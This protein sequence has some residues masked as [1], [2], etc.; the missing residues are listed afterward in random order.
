MMGVRFTA[1]GS[2][3]KNLWVS[4]QRWGRAMLGEGRVNARATEGVGELQ[5]LLDRIH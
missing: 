3:Q 4:G 5:S 2:D 1:V